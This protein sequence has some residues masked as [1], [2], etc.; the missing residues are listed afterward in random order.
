MR[1]V[2]AEVVRIADERPGIQRVVVVLDHAEAIAIV[3]TA[4]SGACEVGEQ[5]LLNTTAV[6]LELGTGGVH[7][8]VARAGSGSMLQDPS[9][10]H[11]MKMRYSPLQRDVLS[12][13]EE[14][15][16]YAD[17]MA[18]ASDLDGMPVVCCGL[19]SQILPVAAA[20]K[21]RAA[22][23]R[24]AYVMT[25][26][27]SLPLALS[28]LVAEMRAVGLLDATI[29]AGQA[30]GGE[31]ETVTLHSAL[32]AA[33]HVA[34]ADVTIVALGPGMTGTATP[35][36]H[37]GVAAGEA[38][39]AVAALGGRP[40]AVLRMSFADARARHHGVSHH[41]LVALGRVALA[42]ATVAMPVI[43][44][45][46]AEGVEAALDH[47]GVWRRHTRVDVPV[48]ALPD[49]RGVPMRSMGRT[50]D[51]DPVF[52]AAG[53]AGGIVAAGMCLQD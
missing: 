17:L 36:G 9:G 12:V 4:L 20:I 2:W 30:F 42:R 51:D 6:D 40:V 16:E 31:F 43:P 32:L 49:T 21:E 1:L 14:A 44:P 13:E 27:A 45:E 37:G 50:P 15:S 19:H 34:L 28:D 48:G 29:T 38:I 7:F 10:G 25:D 24:I 22:A 47:A 35:F 26:G 39:N 33:K 23:L 5:V 18:E 11:I 3:Y 8:V 52:F 53:C 41:S 46:H